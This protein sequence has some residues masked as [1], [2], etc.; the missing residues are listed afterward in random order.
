MKKGQWLSALLSISMGVAVTNVAVS[1]I[2]EKKS[3]EEKPIQKKESAPKKNKAVYKTH[4]ATPSRRMSEK[5]IVECTTLINKV[6]QTDKLIQ[7]DMA[8]KATSNSKIADHLK[9]PAET[10]IFASDDPTAIAHLTGKAT[11]PLTTAPPQPIIN[12]Q[13][14]A[15]SPK[16]PIAKS[17]IL[18][19][20][21]IFASDDPKAI[22]HLTG[23]IKLPVPESRTKEPVAKVI[24]PTSQEAK[25]RLSTPKPKGA[26]TKL[27][28][29][30]DHAHAH[31]HIELFAPNN[32]SI[33]LNHLEG[34]SAS[35]ASLQTVD[36]AP[37]KNKKLVHK[38]KKTNTA[39]KTTTPPT[40]N[41][42]PST[43]TPIVEKRQ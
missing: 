31:P 32:S 35:L 40:V 36:N 3:A 12:H 23:K 39:K 33:D 9:K 5:D 15:S 22:A 43:T 16:P 26:T 41:E 2:T 42:K 11:A 7:Q 38:A 37:K 28:T 4:L 25:A 13:T 21:Q 34:T 14:R 30:T 20:S 29:P 18:P 1:A 10:Q 17:N 8:A 19:N 27:T 6:A 24:T